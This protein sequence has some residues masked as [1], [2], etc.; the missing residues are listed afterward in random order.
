MYFFTGFVMFHPVLFPSEDPV[1]TSWSERLEYTGSDDPE[2]WSDFLQ[3]TFAL[4]GQPGRSRELED[5]RVS[6]VYQ[7]PGVRIEA[8]VSVDRQTVEITRT[9]WGFRRLMVGYH[10]V[11]GY[12]GSWLYYLWSLMYDLASAACIVFAVTGILIWYPRRNRDRL[13]WLFLGTGFGLTLATILYLM[14]TP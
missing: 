9:E 7:R 1:K 11:H 8:F 12:S 14:Y 5:G 2:A 4:R 13:G 6:C 10:R 3:S